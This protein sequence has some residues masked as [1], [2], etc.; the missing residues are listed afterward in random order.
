MW[1][2]LQSDQLDGMIAETIVLNGAK[3]DPIHAYFSRPLYKTNLPSIVLIPHIPGW[4][5][6]CRETARRFT[7]H[8]YM[9]ICPNIYERV[10]HGN[11][12]E[13]AQKSREQGGT[14]DE[15]V[16]GDT[17]ACI[18][19]L[20]NDPQSN[21]KVGVIG[22]CSGGRHAFLAACKCEG[23]DAAVDCW[24][25]NTVQAEESLNER[26]PVSPA[27]LTA[28]LQCPLLG[29]FGNDDK[30]PD[31]DEVNALEAELKKNNKDYE[32]H[33]YDGAGHGIWYYHT[34]MYRPEAAI[35][36]FNK[37]IDFFDKNLK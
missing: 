33:R 21:H 30:R 5:E 12:V 31:V 35:D 6:W 23:L 17:Q 24:G 9:V 14:Y 16:L 13:I 32:F 36:S 34:P 37:V 4:D 1:N 10:G 18:D 8:G 28:D 22:M 29:I 19:M 2:N 15:N 3:G 26:Q 7:Q 20:K 27:S 11:V 25:G